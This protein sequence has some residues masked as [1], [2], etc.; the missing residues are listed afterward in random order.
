MRKLI[1]LKP[2]GARRP[3]GTPVHVGP[4][5]VAKV[6]ISLIDYD[7]KGVREKEIEDIK[8]IGPYKEKASITWIN[9]DGLHDVERLAPL[10]ELFS[11]HPL[12]FEDILNTYQ[13]PKLDNYGAYMFIV[14]KMLSIAG[15]GMEISGEQVSLVLGPNFVISFQER[16]G[17]VF[18]TI[19]ER[20][21][22][23]AGRIRKMGADYLA[24]SL[25]D[26]IVDNYFG[27]LERYGEE[28]EELEERVISDPSPA[29]LQAARGLKKEIMFLRKCVWPLREVV[30][31]AEK[32]ES[33]LFAKG[34]MVFLRDLYDHTIQVMD[35]IE[36]LRDSIVGMLD[37]YMSSV[38]NRMNEVMKVLTIIATLFI[39]VTFVAGV[40]GMNFEGM[41]ELKS[42]WG[43]PAVLIVMGVTIGAMLMFFRRKKWL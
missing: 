30:G 34:T 1:H 2:Q 7:E 32:S 40:Y 16:E 8:E 18:E 43:Y 19:R 31:A 3:P 4:E 41:P 10:G 5:R 39:P 9:V 42:P 28:I 23:G 22:T 21:R 17:D 6:K 24:Y 13:R 11:L 35:A 26:A 25:L 36:T 27:I 29:T 15:N 14:A 37:V 12:V 20:I 38:S 33:K